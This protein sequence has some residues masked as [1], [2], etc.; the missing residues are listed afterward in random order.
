MTLK[1]AKGIQLGQKVWKASQNTEQKDVEISNMLISGTHLVVTP[2]PVHHL[3]TPGGVSVVGNPVVLQTPGPVLNIQ[4]A[5]VNLMFNGPIVG[6]DRVEKTAVG[7]SVSMVSLAGG[8]QVNVEFNP[9][10]NVPDFPAESFFDVYFEVDFPESDAVLAN[11]TVEDALFNNGEPQMYSGRPS[12]TELLVGE[13]EPCQPYFLI[14]EED[15]WNEGL[16]MEWPQANIIPMTLAEWN[17]PD[18][19]YM[20]QWGAHLEDGDPYPPVEFLPPTL[21]VYP[22]DDDEGTPEPDDAGLVMTWGDETTPDGEYASAWKFDYGLDPDLTNSIITVTATP[23]A[24]INNISLGLQDINGAIRSWHWA[25]GTAA[26]PSGV[27]TTITIDTTMTGPNA[28]SPPATGFAN[29]PAFNL[30][31]VQYII[32]DENGTWVAQQGAVP[33]GGQISAIWNY[34]HNLSVTPKLPATGANS[35]WY[36]KYSQPPL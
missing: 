32:A 13:P 3:G 36:V 31:Q 12:L 35:K 20:A 10:R 22:G 8:V 15:E 2:L 1:A 7:D 28:A 34:W 27:P 29:N 24:G 19:G 25:C 30:T 14:D 5:Q 9:P 18:F 26:V 6:V 4:N 17:D 21:Y 23:P 33:P 11:V 16:I